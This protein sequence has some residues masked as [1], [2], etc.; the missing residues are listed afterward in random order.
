MNEKRFLVGVSVAVILLILVVGLSQAQGPD[1]PAGAAAVQQQP[2]QPSGPLA[3]TGLV[4]STFSY[5]GVLKE[6]GNPVTGDRQMV[7]RLYADDGCT[8]MVGSPMTYTVDVANGLFHVDLLVDPSDFDGQ[9]LWLETDVGGVSVGCEAIQTVPYALGLR[10]GATIGPAPDG[11]AGITALSAGG[12]ITD[13]HPGGFYRAGG[14]FAGPNGAIGAASSN[15]SNG[16]GVSGLAQGAYGIGVYGWAS[17]ESGTAS[18]VYG[19][20]DSAA[21]RGGYFQNTAGGA[22]IE[23]GGSGNVAQTRNGN[24]MI[25]A[26]V[27]AYC[28]GGTFTPQISRSFNTVSSATFS[29]S[30]GTDSGECIIDFNFQISDRFWVVSAD[31]DG[32]FFASCTEGASN[33]RLNCGQ[34]N[35]NG[36]SPPGY[37]MVLIY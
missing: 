4:S 30:A 18:G 22:D 25:K 1:G 9:A 28:A 6:S 35:Y 31:R 32:P 13:V 11:V 27:R 21:G 8:G 15:Y 19:R 16:Y 34:Y 24:G 14:E 29:I 23:L 20:S 7:F 37:I 5:Q 17:A 12:T 36:G 10:P 26:A 33:D 2:A 3:A